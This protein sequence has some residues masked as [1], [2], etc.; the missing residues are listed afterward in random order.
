MSGKSLVLLHNRNAFGAWAFNCSQLRLAAA[1]RYSGMKLLYA[2][3]SRAGSTK[4]NSTAFSI[5]GTNTLQTSSS[6][7]RQLLLEALLPYKEK[8]LKVARSSLRDSEVKVTS[9]GTDVCSSMA[10]W[11]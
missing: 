11:P 3:V 5:A 2:L 1:C 4:D 6:L 8:I 10:W 9:M 7:D